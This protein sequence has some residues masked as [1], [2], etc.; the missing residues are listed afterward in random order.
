MVLDIPT[1]SG[2]ILHDLVYL[3]ALALDIPGNSKGEDTAFQTGVQSSIVH[4]RIQSVPVIQIPQ[5]QG[6]GQ[7][8]PILV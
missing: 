7:G 4:N 1:S 6:V 5:V 3:I 8:R 2:T